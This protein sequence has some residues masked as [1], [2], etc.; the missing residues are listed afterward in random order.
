MSDSTSESISSQLSTSLSAMVLLNSSCQSVVETSIS[1]HPNTGKWYDDVQSGLDAVQRLVRDWRLSGNLYFNQALLDAV[2][3][4][5][6]VF[7]QA[8][9]QADQYFDQLSSGFD[10]TIQNN[11]IS[12]VNGTLSS[13]NAFEQISQEYNA[14]LNDWARRVEE[15]QQRLNHIVSEI[16][17]Q[18]SKLQA[19]IALANQQIADMEK[20]IKADRE[21][22]NKAKSEE[23][24]GI[25]ETVFGVVF[26]PFTGGLSLI[27][28]GVGVSSIVEAEQAV[29]HLQDTIKKSHKNITT[30][31]AE[32]SDDQKQVVSLKALLLSVGTV[33]NDGTYIT[34]A[35]EALQTTVSSIKQEADS[36]IDKLSQAKTAD[37]LIMEKVWFDAAL[38][39]WQA[40][41]ETAETLSQAS[42]SISRV[43]IG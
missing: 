16:Q 34:T 8:K 22:I 25:F 21:A 39:E 30:D 33:V 27:L 31:Q 36:V 32:L 10:T 7:V 20:Q 40:I 38:E 5:A 14:N 37:Q 3:N 2:T 19:D 24:K 43:T 18:E 11:L 1:Q 42:P 29:S 17:A 4:T 12:V 28:A 41:F 23:N 6:T 35:L 9:K 26:A 15:A 13:V